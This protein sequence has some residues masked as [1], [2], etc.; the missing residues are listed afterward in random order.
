MQS[1]Q[2]FRVLSRWDVG[3]VVSEIKMHIR[4]IQKVTLHNMYVFLGYVLCE[5]FL[6]LDAM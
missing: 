4:A 6:F 2:L 1:M 3:V 5:T